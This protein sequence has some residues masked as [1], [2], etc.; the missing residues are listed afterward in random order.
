MLA[1]QGHED[2]WAD[3][4]RSTSHAFAF[5]GPDGVGRRTTAVAWAAWSNCLDRTEVDTRPCGRCASCT[6]F[7]ASTSPDLLVKEPRTST[8]SGRTARRKSIPI[9]AIVRRTGPT[10]DPQPLTEW[11]SSRPHGRWKIAVVDAADAMTEAASN[12]LL[13]SLEEPPSWARIVLIAPST[14]SL[15]PTI[16]SRCNVVR[17]G[18]SNVERFAHLAP[19]PA[20]RTGSIGPLIRAEGDAEATERLREACAQVV[21]SLDGPLDEALRAATA[22]AEVRDDDPDLA[23]AWLLE[24]IRDADHDR[25]PE[26]LDV[27]LEV[28]E[29]FAAYVTKTVVVG[30]MVLRLRRSRNRA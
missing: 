6:T 17:F 12:A 18:A 23:D 10:S 7:L 4:V 22:W 11:I 19:H 2:V 28:R 9:D 1:L 14:S 3:L 5:V 21:T 26:A 16:V 29:A 25:Y 24:A 15:L 27:V 8:R 13:K 20:L 30:T